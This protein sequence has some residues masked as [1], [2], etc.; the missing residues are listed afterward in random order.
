M[1][2]HLQIGNPGPLPVVHHTDFSG[3][4]PPL[5]ASIL[6]SFQAHTVLDYI[7]PLS[8]LMSATE[9]QTKL[10]EYICELT[11]LRVDLTVYTQASIACSCLLLAQIMTK[12]G[13]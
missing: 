1:V 8:K 6:L 4:S 9:Q 3:L 12:T 5:L 10:A 2:G 7:P 13:E 11:L